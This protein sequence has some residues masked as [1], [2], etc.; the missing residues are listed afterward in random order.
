VRADAT[1][2]RQVVINLV[3]NAADAT[4]E[5]GGKIVI[6]TGVMMADREILANCAAGA[7][8]AQGEYAF[9]E[10][11][12]D[13]VGM[14]PD[15]RERIFDPFF[16]TKNSARG[17]GL[18]AVLGIVRGHRGALCVRSTPGA[19]S[20]FRM[21]LSPAPKSAATNPAAEL[22][23]ARPRRKAI[24]VLMIED[25]EPVRTVTVEMLKL[26]GYAVEAVADGHAGVALYRENPGRFDLVLLDLV[27]PGLSGEQTLA[28]L[29][30]L[31]PDVRVLLMSGSGERTATSRQSDDPMLGFLSKPFTREA[32]ERGIQ[33]LIG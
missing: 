2:I 10:V 23:P 16:T 32:L 4:R 6:R 14:T 1:Q 27:L 17:L 9:L 15:V 8:L 22:P 25:E 12:D 7:G 24:E 28:T 5:R 19:G 3:L 13:G 26:F 31:N 11:C 29:R 33:R 20:T 18:A 21:L 30:I